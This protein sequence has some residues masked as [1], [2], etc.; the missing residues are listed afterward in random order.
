VALQRRQL[1][2]QSTVATLLDA[3]SQLLASQANQTARIDTII[4]S[5]FRGNKKILF[6]KYLFCVQP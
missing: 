4:V 5:S 1:A 3:I 6:S 2:D